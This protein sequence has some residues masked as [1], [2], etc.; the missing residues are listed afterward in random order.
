M[1]ADLE[2]AILALVDPEG[3]DGGIVYDDPHVRLSEVMAVIDS[4]GVLEPIAA[5]VLDDYLRRYWPTHEGAATRRSRVDSI[6]NRV[7][8]ARLA[9]EEP[10]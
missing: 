7:R 9:G 10:E 4:A 6:L 5:D 8:S 2:R 3:I 1:N